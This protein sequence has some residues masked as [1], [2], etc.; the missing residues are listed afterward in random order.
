M[1]YFELENEKLHIRVC[2]LGAELQSIF[3]KQ[4]EQ[5]NLCNLLILQIRLII[6]LMIFL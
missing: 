3:N 4:L 5:E 1:A 6:S 2:S